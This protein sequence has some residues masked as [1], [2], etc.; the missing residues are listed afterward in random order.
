MTDLIEESGKA[1]DA[2]WSKWGTLDPD[3]MTHLINPTFMGGPRWPAMRQAFRIAR[4]DGAILI[5][6]DGLSDPFDDEDRPRTNG[7]G[8][9][10]YAIT[11]DSVPKIPGSWFWNLVWQA[12]QLCAS[13]G[14]VASLLD[15]L[16][17]ISTELYDVAIP[18][19]HA[20]RFVNEHGRVAVLL[21]QTAKDVPA[22]I[23]GP[24]S[25]IKLVSLHLLTLD[26]LELVLSKGAEGR[27][28][29]AARFAREGV[30]GTCTLGRPSVV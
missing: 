10:G 21:G 5:A 12:S 24:L 23:T 3:V 4:R 7:F 29:L 30:A 9:E 27:K 6:S 25:P 1:R 19:A 18:E 14:Q 26:E 2:V 22:Q 11:S 28:Q 17:L 15:E 20:P 16:K 8:L 13:N